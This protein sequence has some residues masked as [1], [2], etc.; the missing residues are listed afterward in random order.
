MAKNIKN[1]KRIKSFNI[2]IIV[3]LLVGIV[4]GWISS[5]YPELNIIENTGKIITSIILYFIAIILTFLVHIL[6]HEIG[7]LIFGLLSGYKFVSFRVGSHILVREDRGFK[8]KRFNIPGTAGQCLMMPPEI[9]DGEFPFI[10]YNLGGVLVNLIVAILALLYSKNLQLPY[11]NLGIAIFISGIFI[12]ITNGIPMK[13]GGMPNDGYNTI[14]MIKNRKSREH[15]YIQLKIN[16]LLT[17]GQRPRDISMEEYELDKIEDLE[18]PLN[19][20]IKLMEYYG[21]LDRGDIQ[22]AKDV[23]DFLVPY[24]GRIVPIYRYEINMER[25]FLELI[26]NVNKD[27]IDNLYGDTLKKY[28]SRDNFMLNKKRIL[29][30]YELYYNKDKDRALKYFEELKKMAKDHPIKGEVRMELDLAKEMMNQ[31]S[32]DIQ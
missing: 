26:G 15:F 7:H 29:I 28:V 21:Y 9:E 22:K 20:G 14:S 32:F 8:W 11:V 24:L 30:A 23:L 10:I 18:N 25:I 12:F 19:V 2:Y 31:S 16:G 17:F 1:K 6:L 4:L 5:Y 27:F 3:C 13:L